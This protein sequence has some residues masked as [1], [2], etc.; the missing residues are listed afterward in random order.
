ML[1]W[2]R[3]CKIHQVICIYNCSLLTCY[4]LDPIHG[5]LID[6]LQESENCVDE[7]T[8]SQVLS[9]QEQSL[10]WH[11]RGVPDYGFY[12]DLHYFIT[13]CPQTSTLTKM[14][15]EKFYITIDTNLRA[16]DLRPD[17]AYHFIKRI[18]TS[19][20]PRSSILKYGLEDIQ[21]NVVQLQVKECTEIF[22][23]LMATVNALKIENAETTKELQCTK[24]ALRDVTYE[25]KVI[26]KQCIRAEKEASSLEK[27]CKSAHSDCVIL[28]ELVE[29][30]LE[31]SLKLSKAQ[32]L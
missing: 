23:K 16:R 29:D 31:E 13:R 18:A 15:L 22:Q 3:K 30:T 17:S 14:S 21:M 5:D 6:L 8:T 25:M 19:T 28:E 26:K 2:Q 1:S 11:L 20:Q 4:Y 9:G 10:A 27:A 7:S 32:I 12:Q 24:H